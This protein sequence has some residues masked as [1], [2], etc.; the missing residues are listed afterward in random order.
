[1]ITIFCEFRQFS[2]KK[3]RFSQKLML[4]SNFYQN[5]ALFWFKNANF[6]ADFFGKNFLKI[7][8]SI[9][10]FA[11][12]P[13]ATF[14]KRSEKNYGSRCGSAELNWQKKQKSNI[15]VLLRSLGNL[16]KVLENHGS[17]P[18]DIRRPVLQGILSTEL[19]SSWANATPWKIN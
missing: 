15:I 14:L 11:P 16:W 5:L 3:W 6:F 9:P 18:P 2:A 7:I 10:V 8:T 4:W 12:Q 1:M 17:H 13:W 19:V